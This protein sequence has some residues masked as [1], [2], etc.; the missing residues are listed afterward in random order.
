MPELCGKDV[1][2]SFIIP[3]NLD[4]QFRKS[5]ESVCKLNFTNIAAEFMS[6][7]QNF[8]KLSTNGS[9]GNELEKYIQNQVK[10]QELITKLW[11]NS[12]SLSFN[13]I[14]P[15]LWANMVTDMSKMMSSENG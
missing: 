13:P 7:S 2:E 10:L 4:T 11:T 8:T 1:K 3:A 9:N 14:D 6:M 15:N 12:S 5:W